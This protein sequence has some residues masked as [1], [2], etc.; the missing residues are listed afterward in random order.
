VPDDLA[1]FVGIALHL[2]EVKRSGARFEYPDGL[3][4]I[5]WACLSGLT[6][7][8]DRAEGLKQERERKD[9]RKK[10]IAK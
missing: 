2:S 3:S 9:A 4:P 7:G 5:D 1:E 6:R 8:Q 10:K